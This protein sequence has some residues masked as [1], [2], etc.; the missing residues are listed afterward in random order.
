MHYSKV[1]C[2]QSGLMIAI[3]H[4]F[5]LTAFCIANRQDPLF[6]FLRRYP[7]NYLQGTSPK[8]WRR[9]DKT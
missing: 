8:T 9:Y 2:E 6:R 1:Y 5:Q 4:I 3:K 7:L